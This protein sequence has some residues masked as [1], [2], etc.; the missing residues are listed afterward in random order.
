MNIINATYI[1]R[2]QSNAENIKYFCKLSMLHT[3]N[4]KTLNTKQIN[5]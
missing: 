5:I 3:I 2:S 1:M 4:M